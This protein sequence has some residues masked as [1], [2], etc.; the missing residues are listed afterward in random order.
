MEAKGPCH[1]PLVTVALW[2]CDSLTSDPLVLF[3]Y[4]AT[5]EV[6]SR[7]YPS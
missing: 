5:V 1:A 2:L 3:L 6:G 7:K 4:P